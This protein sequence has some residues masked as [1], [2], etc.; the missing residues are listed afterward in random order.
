MCYYVQGYPDVTIYIDKIN[1]QRNIEV[2][3]FQMVFKNKATIP[4]DLTIENTMNDKDVIF[5]KGLILNNNS[6]FI[7]SKAYVK[8]TGEFTMAE[9]SELECKTLEC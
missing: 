3:G 1:I 9:G 5:Q 8:V 7:A 4:K 6:K 2:R